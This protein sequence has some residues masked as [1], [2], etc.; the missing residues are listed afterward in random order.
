MLITINTE[1]LHLIAR[2]VHRARH[3][4]QMTITVTERELDAAAKGSSSIK[5]AKS[6]EPSP[7]PRVLP[8]LE[9]GYG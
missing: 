7:H 3:A 8:R 5:D 9:P 4:L 1:T 2:R 6:P